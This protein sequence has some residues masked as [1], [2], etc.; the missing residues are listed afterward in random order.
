MIMIEAQ[1]QHQCKIIHSSLG[2]P[3][4]FIEVTGFF[5]YSK[6]TMSMGLMLLSHDNKQ[7]KILNFLI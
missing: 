5:P 4:A 2:E 6:D 3:V 1:L 7:K